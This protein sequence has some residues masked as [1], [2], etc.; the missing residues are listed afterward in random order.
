MH[1]STI[2]PS[3]AGQWLNS[4]PPFFTLQREA[5]T[6]A[7][8]AN[9]Q[10]ILRQA[11][12]IEEMRSQNPSGYIS[13]ILQNMG[14]EKMEAKNFV[15]VLN[16]FLSGEMG[17]KTIS[18]TSELG[19]LLREF[20][21]REKAFE[22]I[23]R[24]WK[25]VSEIVVE[26]VLRPVRPELR[27]RAEKQASDLL[28]GHKTPKEMPSGLYALGHQISSFL[29]YLNT[30]VL[31][32]PGASAASQ[33]VSDDPCSD[34]LSENCFKDLSAEKIHEMQRIV[35]QQIDEVRGKNCVRVMGYT[36]SGKSTFINYLSSDQ[37]TID[38]GGVSCASNPAPAGGGHRSVTEY[39]QTHPVSS[40][41]LTGLS[42][43]TALVDLPG[44]LG[45]GN[46]A[47]INLIQSMLAI[48]S[49]LEIDK[50]AQSVVD[51]ILID[52]HSLFTE[53][54]KLQ[55]LRTALHL[56][57]SVPNRVIIITKVPPFAKNQAADSPN[58][59]SLKKELTES[60]IHP[61]LVGRLI[62]YH[63]GDNDLALNSSAS[64]GGGTNKTEIIKTIDTM[65]RKELARREQSPGAQ[66]QVHSAQ[67]LTSPQMRDFFWQIRQKL[68]A[69]LDTSSN[70]A[71][72]NQL[73]ERVKTL[74]EIALPDLLH[75]VESV[76]NNTN[77]RGIQIDSQTKFKAMLGTGD[78]KSF[79]HHFHH[80]LLPY[81]ENV[82][83][84]DKFDVP[85]L[86]KGYVNQVLGTHR[87]HPGLT[88]SS[89][90]QEVNQTFP[91]FGPALEK[92]IEDHLEQII[93]KFQ[94]AISVCGYFTDEESQKWKEFAPILGLN[95]INID[96]S[97]EILESYPKKLEEI[98]TK[99]R[100]EKE[101]K[102]KEH[103]EMA[104]NL[105]LMSTCLLGLLIRRSCQKRAAQYIEEP[106]LQGRMAGIPVCFVEVNTS[107]D[108]A[109]AH[110][111]WSMENGELTLTQRVDSNT[112][113]LVKEGGNKLLRPVNLLEQ[114]NRRLQ[115]ME[116]RLNEINRI[117]PMRTSEIALIC[118]SVLTSFAALP[119]LAQLGI[120]A[121]A[122]Y[123]Y[124]R[125]NQYTF[126]LMKSSGLD[127]LVLNLWGATEASI[128]Q[129]ACEQV[130]LATQ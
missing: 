107:V 97:L 62:L 61:D 109:G 26:D 88:S 7:D 46:H 40:E 93:L 59:E 30:K 56:N 51:V 102:I 74:I 72:G 42:E 129:E 34:I 124:T 20:R 91:A 45:N 123:Q 19:Q 127:S 5:V 16:P 113:V 43:N 82:L 125:L 116:Q 9:G 86:V 48:Q 106:M 120:G 66:R 65:Q 17:S 96:K 80:Q 70:R 47:L 44:F 8:S 101:K 118:S 68:R 104:R 103:L 52:Y 6:F 55:M 35:K 23:G 69:A 84:K 90:I 24:H 13:A 78:P 1:L 77:C 27:N 81:Q 117:A 71:Q 18:Q 99:F 41:D 49:I 58:K 83:L 119:Y 21:A 3:T 126:A 122:Y 4:T 128:I 114:I 25:R 2:S 64:T 92:A 73:S 67:S 39:M 76:I 130:T 32:L 33:F 28:C 110:N 14:F 29:N 22:T 53:R 79:L 37:C 95:S 63:V 100:T 10:N 112:H 115:Q 111:L 105:M 75:E 121:G 108:L 31:N 38:A 87:I 54:G 50:V 57:A 15:R 94:E 98:Q 36:G 11:T 85:S 89:V 12:K 60:G